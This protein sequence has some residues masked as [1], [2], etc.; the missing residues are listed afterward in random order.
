MAGRAT[1]LLYVLNK[2]L[3]LMGED[4]VAD[5]AAPETDAGIKAKQFVDEAIDEAQQS[6]F[7]QELTDTVELTKE[8]TLHHDGRSRF[9][10]PADCLRPL[11]V[12]FAVTVAG[13]ALEVAL[14]NSDTGPRFDI[15]GNTILA[16]AEEVKLHYTKR[17]DDPTDSDHAWTAELT[18][19]IYHLLA[20]NAAQYVTGNADV[21]SNLLAK[22]EQFVKPHAKLLQSRYRTS[23]HWMPRGFTNLLS[24][25]S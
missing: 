7:W 9:V 18:R 10:L 25:Y 2:A 1:D 14:A 12:K 5:Y 17:V 13:T 22:Y 19:C 8:G 6:F 20:A 4:P 15:E 11:A 21:A 3:I 24:R 16:Y 23:D